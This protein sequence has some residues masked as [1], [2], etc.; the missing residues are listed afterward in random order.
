[1]AAAA[2]APLPP[3]MLLLL[4]L[5]PRE[6]GLPWRQR[7]VCERELSASLQPGRQAGGGGR[8]RAC[9]ATRF[10]TPGDL[11]G[12]PSL[13]HTHQEPATGSPA[14]VNQQE[15]GSPGGER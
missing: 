14:V 6:S 7:P 2:L 12:S 10:P 4:L 15:L 13:Y 8:W 3:L 11:C 1:M 5:L 9:L